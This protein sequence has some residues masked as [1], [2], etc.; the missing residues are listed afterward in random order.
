MKIVF[1]SSSVHETYMINYQVQNVQPGDN[2]RNTVRQ[3]SSLTVSPRRGYILDAKDFIH[4]MLP[5]GIT[6]VTFSNSS[7]RIDFGN[8]V[9]VNI[10]LDPSFT[11][12]GIQDIIFD[13]PI[14]GMGRLPSNEI[15]LITSVPENDNIIKTTNLGD[16]VVSSN[17]S[18]DKNNILHT[19]YSVV[20]KIGSK[21]MLF[22][23]EFKAFEGHYLAKPPTYKLNV[24]NRS[25]YEVKAFNT[26]DDKKRL[27]SKTITVYYTFPKEN[28]N[29]K[30]YMSFDAISNIALKNKQD[31]DYS[32]SL[33]PTIYS[34]KV[35]GKAP[36]RGG[37]VPVE[38]RG[39]PGSPFRVAIQNTA[40]QVY[41]VD[42][43]AFVT[44]GKFLEGVIPYSNKGMGVYKRYIKMP[45]IYE[46][47]TNAAANNYT[48]NVDV[49]DSV[50]MR[51]ITDKGVKTDI[52]PLDDK[53]DNTV[54][55]QSSGGS[56]EK[57]K[58]KQAPRSEIVV[59][60]DY[61][62][63][64]NG[65]DG[66]SGAVAFQHTNASS[67]KRDISNFKAI[68]TVALS[69]G[70]TQDTASFHIFGT[71]RSPHS[72]L[73][74]FEYIISP[75]GVTYGTN[76]YIRIIRQPKF[77]LF[78]GTEGSDTSYRPWT[79]ASGVACSD[80][81]NKLFS[82]NTGSEL[83]IYNDFLAHDG[84]ENQTNYSASYRISAKIKGIGT[85]RS[86]TG[87]ASGDSTEY[88]YYKKVQI[89][90]SINAIVSPT[91]KLEIELKLQNL[92]SL[93]NIT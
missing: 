38:V 75:Y 85:S 63:S 19:T 87:D 29:T 86:S 20:G 33:T 11:A 64:A 22:Q 82:L 73:Y 26:Y 39:V 23:K 44:G 37:F 9:I 18:L 17:I 31:S 72:Y 21:I 34:F 68:E 3:S 60:P 90:G 13:I 25:R 54:I 47:T 32:K 8:K 76:G 59:Y 93:K 61:V 55:D 65:T 15:E 66:A 71:A 43:G 58:L 45:S 92:L 51:L 50:E 74:N 67:T 56:L 27:T 49:G 84:S 53:R 89:I 78:N 2:V 62:Y 77:V 69:D 14:S 79:C 91:Q 1:R 5:N 81:N 12:V 28:F 70:A 16:G 57:T 52:K 6:S 40:K 7:K 10:I 46:N 88:T 48:S 4:G 42:K 30:D 83:K 80:A 36:T 24:K 35:I 41:D